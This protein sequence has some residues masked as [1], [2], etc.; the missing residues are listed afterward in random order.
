[1]DSR[2]PP[3][4]AIVDTNVVA[5]FLLGTEP[6]A[7]EA[8]QFLSRVSRP[9]APALW[10]AE[11]ANVIWMATRTGVISPDEGMVRLR[12]AMRLGVE[13]VPLH[14]LLQGALLRAVASGVAVYDCVFVELAVREDC[15][16]ATFDR[17]VLKAFPDVACRPKTLPSE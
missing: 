10:E 14:S 4:K 8:R 3:M 2:R 11:V 1:M 9:L 7:A 6:F 12:L 16:L 5:Y 17:A 15:P 13:S